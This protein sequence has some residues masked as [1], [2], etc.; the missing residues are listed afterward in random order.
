MPGRPGLKNT[1]CVR[2]TPPI[3]ANT[4]ATVAPQPRRPKGARIAVQFVVNYEE[5]GKNSILDGDAASEGF[6]TEAV[7]TLP[8]PRG[9]NL[10]VESVCEYGARAGFWRL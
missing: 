10:S 4:S 5:G 8:S 9:R 2:A 6:E 1:P 3:P 7:P